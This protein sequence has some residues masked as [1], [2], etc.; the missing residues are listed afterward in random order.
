MILH[1]LK[2]TLEVAWAIV[3]AVFLTTGPIVLCILSILMFPFIGIWNR[4]LLAKINISLADLNWRFMANVME[5][6]GNL[7][8][9]FYGDKI[10]DRETVVIISNHNTIIDWAFLFPVGGRR[11]RLGC[12]KFFAKDSVK[13]WPGFGW[14]MY[15]LDGIFL[16]R[17]WADDKEG[18]EASFRTLKNRGL[19]FWTLSY[20]E[21]TRATK[22]KI[23]ESQNFCKSRG[24]PVLK[25]ILYPRT[26]G[27]VATVHGLRDSI[28]AI[29]DVTFT[30]EGGRLPTIVDLA[31]R[32]MPK[33]H[34]HIKRYP[35]DTLPIEDE[36]I[37]K[38]CEDRYLEKDQ[39]L[40]NF[41]TDKV[42]PDKRPDEEWPYPYQHK[43]LHVW[44]KQKNK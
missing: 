38:W 17:N 22:S 43:Y 27:F 28:D 33:V 4:Y 24:K 16:K 21:G 1:T 31:M 18:I 11:G 2:Y 29:Y 8:M 39:L 40:E 44:G 7:K 42:F 36:E 9:E 14:G 15:L 35:I 25:N 19:P 6:W 3:L 20:L 5:S 32:R 37:V 41:K 12:I 30:F 13:Y 26:K 23:L 34:F 10:P